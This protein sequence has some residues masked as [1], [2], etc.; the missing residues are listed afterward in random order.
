VKSKHRAN[1][2]NEHLGEVSRTSLTT[3]VKIFGD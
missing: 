3:F 2:T 1:Q